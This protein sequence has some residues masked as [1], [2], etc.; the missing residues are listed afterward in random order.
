MQIVVSCL[1]AVAAAQYGQQQ[2]Y[3]GPYHIPVIGPNGVPQ[4]TPEVVAARR[5][6]LAA[7][8]GLPQQAAPQYQGQQGQYNGQYQGQQA[9]YNAQPQAPVQP[10]YQGP[11]AKIGPDGMPQY[12]PA[13]AAV[14]Q[15]HQAAYAETLQRTAALQSQSAGHNHNQQWGK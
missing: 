2:H 4:E 14:R 10:R 11:L 6:H 13:V 1:L 8:Q 5:N 9:Q 7:F 12:D 3:N 15:A